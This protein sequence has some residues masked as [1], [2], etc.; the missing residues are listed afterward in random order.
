M[1]IK[2]SS[3]RKILLAAV[4]LGGLTALAAAGASAAQSAAGV[5]VGQPQPPVTNVDYY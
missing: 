3:M 5:H 4:A 1:V 2:E